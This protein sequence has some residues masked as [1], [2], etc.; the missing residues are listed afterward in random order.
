MKQSQRRTIPGTEWTDT[1]VD[2]C[3]QLRGLNVR[4]FSAD[5]QHISL[6]MSPVLQQGIAK[7]RSF[8]VPDVLPEAL[9]LPAPKSF[10]THH[11]SLMIFGRLSL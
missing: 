7:L 6:I 11:P 10:T 2:N 3:V 9:F 1:L 5:L 8:S 4:L